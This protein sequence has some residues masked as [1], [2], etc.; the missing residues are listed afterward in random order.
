M[1]DF[2]TLFS[3]WQAVGFF[4]YVLPFLFI[5]VVVYGILERI[6][7]F[8]FK[9]D[10]NST[11]H[12]GINAVIALVVALFAV[13]VP[14]VSMFFLEVF[15][16]LGIAAGAIFVLLVIIGV[17]LPLNQNA[18]KWGMFVVFALVAG[19]V[20]YNSFNFMGYSSDSFWDIINMHASTIFGVVV[21]VFIFIA[22]LSGSKTKSPSGG[23]V[24][25]I[26]FR[27]L[28]RT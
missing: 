14:T 23:A 24:D 27:N 2:R 18:L 5:F 10:D 11:P 17:A 22:V 19:I 8:N 21:V 20:L 1:V 15:P 28:G 16:R 3:E 12:R 6:G 26:L 7:I 9:K 13:Q 25:S 4:D